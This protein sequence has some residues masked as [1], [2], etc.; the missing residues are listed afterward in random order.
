M[1]VTNIFSRRHIADDMAPPEVTVVPDYHHLN[2]HVKPGTNAPVISM[3]TLL[4]SLGNV[5]PYKVAAQ[6]LQIQ[7][8]RLLPWQQITTWQQKQQTHQQHILTDKRLLV[9]I[10]T[11]ADLV[12]T[13]YEETLSGGNLISLAP[14]YYWRWLKVHD[15]CTYCAVF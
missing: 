9:N 6:M 14:K 1:F 2:V 5:F 8:P 11:T 4:R 13:F 10:C 12:M 7:I 3:D 15:V